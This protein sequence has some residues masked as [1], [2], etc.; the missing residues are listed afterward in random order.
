ML[1]KRGDIF[2]QSDADA[3]C[4]TSNGVVKGNGEL[5]MGAGIA[6]AFAERYPTAPRFFGLSVESGGNHVYSMFGY[7]CYIVNY[8][9]KTHWRFTSSPELI[10]KSAIQLVELTDRMLWHRVYLTRPGCGLG[11]LDWLVLGPVIDGILDDRFVVLVVD[12]VG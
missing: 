9:T 2:K 3:I 1:E 11:G 8:P 10:V 12:D 6:K 7:E 5:V 4:F